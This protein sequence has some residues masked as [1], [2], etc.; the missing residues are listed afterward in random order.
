MVFEEG[1]PLLH[2]HLQH[3]V[4]ILPLPGDLQGLPVIPPTVAHLAGHV[5]IRQ[6]VHFDLL[7][8][9]SLAGL[10]PAPLHVEGEAVLLISPGLGLRGQGKQLPDQVEH[11]SIGGGIAAGRPTNGALIDHDD[12]VQ[13]FQ[14]LH[15][16]E[17]S[18]PGLG[19]VQLLGQ[20]LIDDLVHQGA[21]A[22][23]ADPS[24]A[25]QHPQGHLHVH[26]LQVVLRRAEDL[27]VSRGLPS[28]LRH[29]NL[30]RAAEILPRQALRAGLDLLHRA[31]GHDVPTM[32]P[33]SRAHVHDVIRGVHGFLVMLHHQ[34]RVA[35]IPH[36]LQGGDELGVIPLMQADAG[37]IQH[38]QHPHQGGANLSRQ[39]NALGL[40]AGQGA[41]RPGQGQVSQ[42]HIRQ[43]AQPGVDLL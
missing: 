18:R 13:L 22:A 12:L 36:L 30:L 15:P 28:L 26:L 34:H 11:A 31:L 25:A 37:L 24:H 42:A 4:D 21:L 2:R 3:L 7:H 39:A 43:E 8:P 1:E 35:Q 40:A 32:E 9:V 17:F 14:P 6:E 20:I 19:P 29:G 41:R 33:R 5:Q 23:A 27:Q 10:A 38:I 16:V